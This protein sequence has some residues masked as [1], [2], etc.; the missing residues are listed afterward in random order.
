MDLMARAGLQLNQPSATNDS[1]VSLLELSFEKE[2]KVGALVVGEVLRQEK[3]SLIIDIGGK[4]EG[5]VFK[6]ELYNQGFDDSQIEE[7]YKATTVHEFF[8]VRDAE[9]DLRYIL[10]TRRVQMVKNWQ[11]LLEMK[12]S[13]QTVE[14][15]VTGTTKGGLLAMVCNIKG[16]IPSSQLRITRPIEEVTGETLPVKVLEV[17]RSRNKLILSHRQAIFEQKAALR[18]ETLQQLQEGDIVEGQVVKV[19]DFG[20]FIDINGIDGLLPLSEITWQRIKHPSDVL[21][22]GQSLTVQVLSIDLERQRISLSLK[23]M[24]PDPWSLVDQQLQINQLI[25]GRVTKTLVSGI[26]A[27]VLPGVEAFCP[28][29]PYGKIFA[30]DEKYPFAILSIAS[31][32]RRIT[33]QYQ[34]DAVV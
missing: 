24:Q 31:S 15:T 16:F 13:A 25:M 33:L 8:L 2:A 26:L 29:A 4:Y 7:Q 5:V 22:L 9:D 3:D 11:Q 28:Y 32:D 19:T 18:Q 12:E 27:E 23:R 14:A 30:V 20:V 1:F 6:K 10:S 17:D 34:P 21:E